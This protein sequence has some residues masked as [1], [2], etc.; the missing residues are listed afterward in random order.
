M[1]QRINLDDLNEITNNQKERLC[2]LWVPQLYDLAVAN[3]CLDAENDQYQQFEFVIGNVIVQ[4]H[5][6]GV[7]VILCNLQIPTK[8]G[9]IVIDEDSE[10]KVDETAA[11]ESDF[12]DSDLMEEDSSEDEESPYLMPGL[13][14][15]SFFNKDECL[16]LL[17]IGQMIDLLKQHREEKAG[18]FIT[19][20]GANTEVF[21]SEDNKYSFGSGNPW[22]NY[23]VE[24]EGEELCDILWECI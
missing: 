19:V 12:L 10:D 3:L 22:S 8:D 20:P 23:Q 18:F 9:A 14:E 16:P 4:N 21:A 2:K 7:R 11:S 6:Q 24:Y 15:V 17:S 13:H 1:K 5:Y